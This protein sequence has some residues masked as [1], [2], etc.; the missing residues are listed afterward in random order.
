MRRILTTAS[1]LGILSLASVPAK[2]EIAWLGF[3]SRFDVGD[4][5]FSLVFGEPGYSYPRGYYYRTAQPFHV[6]GAHCSSSCFRNAG[7]YYH[8]DSCPLVRAHFLRL[9]YDP[10]DVYT[11]YAPRIA[12][13]GRSYGYGSR[14]EGGYDRYHRYDRRYARPTHDAYGNGWG[15]G[16]RYDSR[17]DRRDDRRNDGWRGDDRRGDRGHDRRFD[18]RRQDDRRHE[19]RRNDDRRGGERRDSRFD[20]RRDGRSR[21]HHQDANGRG[22]Q[23]GGSHGPR[24]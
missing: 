2:A 19:V 6:H 12:Y 11:R 16:S 24:R 4:V 9:G 23:R 3:G 17:Y 7:Y 10:Y 8:G 5:H 22:R 14:F 20:S 21:D 18:S 15:H 13:G 1:L